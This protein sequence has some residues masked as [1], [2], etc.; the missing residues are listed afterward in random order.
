[1]NTE[2][3]G[4]QWF[5]EL[6]AQNR[7]ALGETDQDSLNE[8][9]RQ[10]RARLEQLPLPNRKQEP[11][12]YTDLSSLYA[13]SYRSQVQPVTALEP[14]DIERWIYQTDDS[15]RLVFANGQCVPTLS[16]IERLPKTIK[17]GSLRAAVSTDPG[18]VSRW[19]SQQ[20]EQE[21]DVFTALNRA[22][23][24]DGLFVHVAADVNVERP[25]EVVHLNL[26][27]EQPV[28]AQPHSLILL[29]QGANLKLVERFIS[30]GDSAYFFNAVSQVSLG[31]QASLQHYCLQQESA[32][33]H[34]RNR[35]VVYQNANSDYRAMHVATGAAW[36]RTD[37]EVQFGGP[38]AN[39]EL[40]GVYST[41]AQQYTDFHLDV[42]HAQ[43]GCR[44]REDFRG[45]VHGQG[46][47][48]FDGRIVVDKGAQG[49]DAVLSNKNLLLSED[50]EVDTKPQLEIYA[51]D[52]KCGHGTTVGRIDP[53]QLFYLR[54]RGIPEADARRMLCL[55]FAEHILAG[56]GDE[57]LH[58]FM[59][60]DISASLQLED[61]A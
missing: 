42:H 12:H 4:R 27:F 10:A 24:N 7:Q 45:I 17:L 36:S 54:S 20:H 31:E 60:E 26:N 8:T 29:E 40:Q 57:R 56:M 1:M 48:V 55:G 15:F 52:V 30:I 34:H 47:A 53:Q 9:R 2:Q 6:L 61:S 3:T 41:G 50:A 49:S 22:L 13:Q 39:C 16:N 14:D 28:L 38:H 43:P 21:A 25:I 11:W 37:I 51:D 46:R 5:E 44:S 35:T 59:L 33:A 58:D 18:L 32:K 23:L 19:L